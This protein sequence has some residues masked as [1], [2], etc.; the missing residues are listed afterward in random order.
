MELVEHLAQI[1]RDRP[2]TFSYPLSSALFDTCCSFCEQHVVDVLRISVSDVGG[3]QRDQRDR[4]LICLHGI[5]EIW[6]LSA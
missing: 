5:L 6:S 2:N 3:I 1:P 4:D